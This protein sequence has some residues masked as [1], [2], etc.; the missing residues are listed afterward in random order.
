MAQS[1]ARSNIHQNI[2]G[3]VEISV[4]ASGNIYIIYH[5]HKDEQ[6]NGSLELRCIGLKITGLNPWHTGMLIGGGIALSGITIGGVF[7]L[8]CQLLSL[9]EKVIDIFGSPVVQA[10]C[11][12]FEQLIFTKDKKSKQKLM[13]DLLSNI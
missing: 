11:G 3:N 8:S 9:I 1:D 4:N 6:N 13:E 7:Y 12:S 2:G 10:G 5:H